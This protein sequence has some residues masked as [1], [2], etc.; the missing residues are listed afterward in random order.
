MTRWVLYLL[1]Q[2]KSKNIHNKD[3]IRVVI[4]KHAGKMGDGNNVVDLAFIEQSAVGME[5]V[6]LLPYKY[7]AATSVANTGDFKAFI[8]EK[9][10]EDELNMILD[11]A[12][13][14]PGFQYTLFTDEELEYMRNF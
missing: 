7:L 4:N 12:T 14:D 10:Y 9:G 8:K 6:S 1:D 2:Q 13:K 11:D 5:I 3:K